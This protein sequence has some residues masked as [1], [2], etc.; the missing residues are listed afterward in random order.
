[1]DFTSSNYAIYDI[2]GKE[3]AKNTDPPSDIPH[4]TNFANSVREGEE[5][6]LPISEGQISAMLCHLGNM[7]YRTTGAV[8]VDSET[9]ELIDNPEAQ[10]LWGR[11]EYRAGWEV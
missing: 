11:P 10:K 9:G 4:F 2:D 7:A 1:L 6:N 5:L 8:N 3:I